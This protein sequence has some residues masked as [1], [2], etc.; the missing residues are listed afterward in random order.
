MRRSARTPPTPLGERADSPVQLTLAEKRPVRAQGDRS[1]RRRHHRGRR[2]GGGGR[3]RGRRRLRGVVPAEEVRA[4]QQHHDDRTEQ[5][6]EEHDEAEGA[7]LRGRGHPGRPGRRVEAGRGHPAL[8]LRCRP[9]DDA[10]PPRPVRRVL[11]HH[12][13]ARPVVGQV[14][15]VDVLCDL[16][17]VG[18]PVVRC[19]GEI[20]PHRYVARLAPDGLQALD[21]RE[22][23]A[24][25]DRCL[26]GTPRHTGEEEQ[27][28]VDRGQDQP[29]DEQWHALDDPAHDERGER[30]ADHAT[31]QEPPCERDGRVVRGQRRARGDRHTGDCA[32]PGRRPVDLSMIFRPLSIGPRPHL[33]PTVARG[34]QQ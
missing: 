1:G 5:Q 33:P 21:H 28:S 7:A 19:D 29:G 3:P 14:H 15:E 25:R 24:G 34:G 12:D 18:R 22:R 27:Q 4:E 20:E 13:A 31:G 30:R 26:P 8:P 23:R 32:G 16:N 2:R 6:A 10:H 9:L 17:P 11:D